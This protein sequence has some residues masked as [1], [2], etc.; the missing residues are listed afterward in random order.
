MAA[1]SPAMASSPAAGASPAIPPG[2]L[3][4]ADAQNSPA[5]FTPM[6]DAG[7]G[8]TPPL[9]P[10]HPGSMKQMRAETPGTNQAQKAVSDKPSVK[11]DL[12]C[13]EE[14]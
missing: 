9:P 14:I 1:G 2:V 11:A 12:S 10:Q 7:A 13:D 6:F 3:V 5:G 4:K 8:L